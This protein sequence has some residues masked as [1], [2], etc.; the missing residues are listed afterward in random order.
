[1]LAKIASSRQP[2]PPGVFASDQHKPLICYEEPRQAEGQ[3]PASGS[4]DGHLPTP[5]DPEV[6]QLDEEPAAEPD[7]PID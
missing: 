6:M 7:T 4:G 3:P 5:P 1:M 2:V